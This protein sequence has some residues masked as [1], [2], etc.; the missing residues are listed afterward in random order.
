MPLEI[1]HFS[2]WTGLTLKFL[3]AHPCSVYEPILGI[4]DLLSA[5]LRSQVPPNS[6]IQHF[7]VKPDRLTA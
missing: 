7:G 3:V 1:W 4:S 5:V 2:Q 6:L